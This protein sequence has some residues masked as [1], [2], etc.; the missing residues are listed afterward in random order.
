MIEFE[1]IDVQ[2]KFDL[3]VTHADKLST[4]FHSADLERWDHFVEAAII[5]KYKIPKEFFITAFMEYHWTQQVALELYDK[6]RKV[7]DL[8]SRINEVQ[9]RLGQKK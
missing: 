4:N 1:N 7:F 3:F 2:Q 6:Y 9:E 8:K 5:A